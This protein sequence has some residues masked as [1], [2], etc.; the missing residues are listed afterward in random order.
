MTT[1]IDLVNF[2]ADGSCLDAGAWL[3][4]LRGG[5]AA[6][7]HRWL[8][9]YVELRKK[10]VLGLTGA[11]IADVAT[12]NPRAIELINEHPEVFELIVRP[13][14]HDIPLLRSRLGFLRN[15][16]LGLEIAT[17]ELRDVTRFYL[18][19]EFMLTNEQVALL[20]ERG[21]TGVA[22]NAAR[23][24]HELQQRIPD[25]PYKVRGLD[26]RTLNCLPVHGILTQRYLDALHV[27][28]AGPWCTAIRELGRDRLVSWRDGES[29]FLLPDGLQRERCWLQGERGVERVHLRESREDYVEPDRLPDRAYHSYPVHSFTAWMKEF[30][31]LG[32]IGRIQRLEEELPDFDVDELALWLQAINSDVLSA[33]EKRSPVVALTRS[34]DA[35]ETT[36]YTLLRSERAFEGEEYLVILEA[37]RLDRGRRGPLERL[38]R[39]GAPHAIKLG[40]RRDSV[41]RVLRME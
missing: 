28:D 10:V 27:H 22:V 6:P 24:S 12:F 2:N 4:A 7:F 9:L 8:V 35:R 21:I 23:F 1:L 3:L 34:P 41:A 19:P 17:R 33:V 36:S 15:L 39:S 11:T 30:R 16:E 14:S 31:M 37:L 38:L 18:P 40:A 13:F 25:V 29:S 20:D 5:E 32:Y 26:G